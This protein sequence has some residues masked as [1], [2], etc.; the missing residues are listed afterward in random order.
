MKKLLA[1]LIALMMTV[2]SLSVV[3]GAEMKF[4]DVE[5]SDWFYND[6]KIAVESGL[7][8]GKTDTTYC[9]DDNLTY[10]EAIKLAACMN[11]L[12][13]DGK[14]TIKGGDPWYQP[15]VE[16]CK[17]ESI[18]KKEYN[19]SDKVTRAGYM[20]IFASALPEEGLKA[21]NNVPDDSIPDVPS[22]KSY[23]P[24]VYKL[25]RAG[26][27]LGVDTEHNCNPFENIKRSE[28][29]AILTRM[30]NEDKRVSF[31]MGEEEPKTEEPKE[32]EPK[33]DEPKP[34]IKPLAAQIAAKEMVATENEEVVVEVIAK[35]G[36]APYTYE[37]QFNKFAGTSARQSRY[38]YVSAV[39]SEVGDIP[40]LYINGEKLSFTA[41]RTMLNSYK[42]VICT[43]KDADGNAVTTEA[44]KL[45]YGGSDRYN[46]LSDDNFLLYIEDKMWITDRGPVVTGR[47]VNGALH[48]G[49]AVKIYQKD[50]STLTATVEGIEMFKKMLDEARQG[51]NVGILLGGVTKET[52]DTIQKGYALGGY[53]DKYIVSDYIYGTFTPADESVALGEYD[54]INVYFGGAADVNAYIDIEYDYDYETETV[55]SLLDF[56]YEY[57]GVWYVGQTLHIRKNGKEVGTFVVNE[58]AYPEWL[59]E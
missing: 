53:T 18:I 25:Y 4:T 9:P 49:D 50:G 24:A 22:S 16:Y 7:V 29:A 23:A 39:S 28:V 42:D 59:Y 43:V 38:T 26:I 58:I 15:Y 30:M 56:D 31:S 1:T 36:T 20:E 41:T 17:A 13:T 2:T 5:K 6:V 34:E 19:Y 3:F 37:W 8:S 32:E 12:Y 45:T 14:I 11:Q 55:T 57:Y 48:K 54:L 46:D 44:C 47:V 10:A 40:D 35:N 27:L 33:E 21:V 51:D 52:L